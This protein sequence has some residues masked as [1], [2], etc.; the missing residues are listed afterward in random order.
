MC[1]P[2]SVAQ[3]TLFNWKTLL[4]M[5]NQKPFGGKSFFFLC[6][7]HHFLFT[8]KLSLS[9]QFLSQKSPAVMKIYTR[10]FMFCFV[11]IPFC[12]SFS[13]HFLYFTFQAPLSQIFSERVKISQFTTWKR[14]HAT[15][16]KRYAKT[17]NML[18]SATQEKIG[19]SCVL[20]ACQKAYSLASR[21]VSEI[22]KSLYT[23]P[24]ERNIRKKT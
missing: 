13:L 19:N 21:V 7:F 24:Q 11:K 1:V 10:A 3:S 8:L 23:F 4:L 18:P 14:F 2:V 12:L 15:D 9:P 5:N 22:K 17:E 6:K 20:F 16:K